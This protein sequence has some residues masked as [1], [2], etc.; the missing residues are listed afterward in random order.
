MLER[1]LLHALAR[2]I[3]QHPFHRRVSVSNAAVFIDDD[4]RVER[5]GDDGA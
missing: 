4:N 1:A 5:T 2:G 3:A